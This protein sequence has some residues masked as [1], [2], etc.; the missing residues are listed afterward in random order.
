MSLCHSDIHVLNSQCNVEAAR[1]DEWFKANRLTT[2]SKKASN[3]LLS[4]YNCMGPYHSGGFNISMG[5]VRLKRVS[6]VKYL[7]VILDEMVSWSDQIVN[8]SSKLARSAGIFSKL[9]YYLDNS[10]LLQ[11]YHAL[12]NSHLQYGILCWGSTSATNLNNLQILQNR[13]IRNMMKAPRYFRLDNYFLNLRILK[14][15]DLYKFEVAK[16]LHG[17]HN[18]LLPDI[19]S[20]FFN[21]SGANHS[22]NTRSSVNINYDIPF[23]RTSRGQRSILFY[24][25]KVWNGIPIS[26]KTVSKLA[27]KKEYKVFILAGY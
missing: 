8:L 18:N 24:G 17:H 22:H 9:R 1:V 7:G 26:I 2:N 21:E 3:F 20:S 11:M 4:E 10:T 6:K 19:F 14:V 23:C 15:H 25:P 5:N 13:A 12:F 27:F 16:F